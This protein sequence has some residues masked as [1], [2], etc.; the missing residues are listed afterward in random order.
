M[1]HQ[2][3]RYAARGALIAAVAALLFQL[4]DAALLL[5]GYARQAALFP[6]PLDYGEGPLLDQAARLARFESIYPADLSQP[7]YLI[8]NYPP[9]FPLAQ[10]PFVA[11]FGPSLWYGRALSLLG[12]LAAALFIGLTI[13]ALTRDWLGAVAGGLLLLAFPY[14]LYWGP[15]NR[16]D[17][18]ALGLCCAALYAVARQPRTRAGLLV[19][20]LLLVAAIFTRQSYALAAP[21]AGFLFLLRE[22]P[23]RR[24]FELVGITASVGGGLALTLTL[25]TGGGF[26]FH[27]VTSNV[28]PF[29]WGQ[30]ADR[31]WELAEHLP[32]LLALAAGFAA[33]GAW[34]RPPSWW[35]VAPFLLGAVASAATIGKTGSNVNYLFELCAAL[36]L[37]AGCALGWANGRIWLR[38]GI[39]LVLALQVGMM[40]AWSREDYAR[41]EAWRFDRQNEIARLAQVVADAD[42]PVL[43]DEYMGLAPLAGRR[44]EYQPFEFKQLAEAGLWD[45]RPFAEQIANNAFAMIVLYDPPS[46]DS[47]RERWTGRQL[48]YITTEYE[49]G[50]RLGDAV[51]YRRRAR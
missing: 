49:P 51:V 3:I 38:A 34:R 29:F 6:F 7:P 10:A 18:L 46:W 25:A 22:A 50:E 26:F 28:N 2:I 23:R 33:L 41:R 14:L 44:L 35:L 12:V 40:S 37:A 11:L 43:L 47:R 24:A 27:I 45:E 1:P 17:S 21:L 39:A 15:L 19:A 4:A 48:L 32:A 13:H 30:V 42:G 8:A 20:A 31:A 36:S 5:A 16:V 9:L